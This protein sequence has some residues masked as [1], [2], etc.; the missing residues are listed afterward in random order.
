M[1]RPLAGLGGEETW[2]EGLVS[3]RIGDGGTTKFWEE[4]WVKGE[5]S[6]KLKYKR[7]YDISLQHQS[8]IKEM[9]RWE[10][11]SWSWNLVWRR[12][13]FAWEANQLEN[14]MRDISIVALKREDHDSWIWEA[15]SDGVFSVKSAYE[16]LLGPTLVEASPVFKKLRKIVAPSKALSFIW[17]VMLDRIQTKINL[18]RRGILQQGPQCLC[19]LCQHHEER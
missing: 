4:L 17:R 13:L 1:A 18:K 16:V 8:S 3:K 14:M 10:G 9:G 15:A 12:N 7:I 2:F 11:D 5:A 6:L 19:V